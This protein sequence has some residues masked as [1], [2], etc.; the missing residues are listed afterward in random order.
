MIIHF[1]LLRY[2]H[3]LCVIYTY[4]PFIATLHPIPYTTL[5]VTY[6]TTLLLYVTH[7]C[8]FCYSP[9]H[10]DCKITLTGCVERR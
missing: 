4:R 10:K 1:I 9:R 3:T 8:M 5:Y 7:T 6:H 2:R